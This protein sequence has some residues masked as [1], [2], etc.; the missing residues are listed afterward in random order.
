MDNEDLL[1]IV[2]EIYLGVEIKG[3]CDII[4]GV[5]EEVVDFKNIYR[6]YRENL[7]DMKNKFV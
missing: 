5:W 6:D 4:Y 7:E 2:F 3:E 1:E